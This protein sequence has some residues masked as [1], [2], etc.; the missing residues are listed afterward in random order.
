MRN[1]IWL[2]SMKCFLMSVED[3]LKKFSNVNE[4]FPTHF[5]STM[6]FDAFIFEHLMSLAL[7]LIGELIFFF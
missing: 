3:I 6:I 4:H 1:H 7:S 5:S 2:L